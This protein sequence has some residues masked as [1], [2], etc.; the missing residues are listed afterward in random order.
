M[1]WQQSAAFK[2]IYGPHQSKKCL[3][4]CAECADSDHSAHAQGPLLS[5]HLFFFFFLLLLLLLLLLFLIVQLA[6]GD[7]PDYTAGCSD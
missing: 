3:G 4:T 1:I 2:G 6:K 5:I 7:G